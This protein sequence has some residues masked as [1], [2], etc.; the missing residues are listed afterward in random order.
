MNSWTLAPGSP[1]ARGV[2]TLWWTMLAVA[3]AVWIAVVI[4]SMLAARRGAAHERLTDEPYLGGE[5]PRV[6]KMIMVAT[7]LTVAVLF[8]FMAYDFALGRQTPQHHDM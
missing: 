6:H 5:S 2:A 3:T 8:F 1:E 4:A 7:G